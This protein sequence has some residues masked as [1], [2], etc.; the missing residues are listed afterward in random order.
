[1]AQSSQNEAAQNEQ[2]SDVVASVEFA[3]Q[4]V[5]LGFRGSHRAGAFCHSSSCNNR[6]CSVASWMSRQ[7]RRRILLVDDMGS[8]VTHRGSRCSLAKACCSSRRVQI[9]RV[10]PSALDLATGVTIGSVV[11]RKGPS[12]VPIHRNLSVVTHNL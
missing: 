5:S 3:H 10:K 9:S 6:L 1:M 4:H 7:L 2:L 8:S 11:I 12:E